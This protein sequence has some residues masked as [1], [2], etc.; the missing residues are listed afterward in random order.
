MEWCCRGWALWW[1]HVCRLHGTSELSWPLTITRTWHFLEHVRHVRAP[2]PLTFIL[3]PPRLTPHSQE[4]KLCATPFGIDVVGITEVVA[5]AGALVGGLL[6]RQRK[7]ELGKLN[8]QLR[9]INVQLRQQAR[10]GT[11]YAPGELQDR[12]SPLH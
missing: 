11:I 12:E 7:E 4:G 5:V 6:A 1:Q 10:A 9:K 8:E 2:L 3:T